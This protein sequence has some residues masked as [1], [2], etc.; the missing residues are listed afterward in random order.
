MDVTAHAGLSQVAA[1]PRAHVPSIA[2]LEHRHRE[3][4]LRVAELTFDLG[5]L[6]YEMAG[7][8]EYRV[9]VLARR[10]A[11]LHVF[12][13]ELGALE[14]ELAAARDGVSGTCSTC[15]A[16]RSRGAV[17]CWSCGQPLTAPAA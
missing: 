1:E 5:G 12:E 7:R 2:E 16:A 8:N 13:R 6:A 10:A 11:D 9:E 15:G 17:Y 3:L 14:A 4:V